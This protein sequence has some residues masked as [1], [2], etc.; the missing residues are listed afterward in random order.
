MVL[1][2]HD[3]EDES[4]TLGTQSKRGRPKGA[5]GTYHYWTRVISLSHQAVDLSHK[6]NI[7]EDVKN[8]EEL[9]E[10]EERDAVDV[11]EPIF[12]PKTFF[13]ATHNPTLDEY[14]LKEEKLYQ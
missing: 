13:I 12:N 2:D 9:E 14:S 3:N 1:I 4:V 6:Y 10:G 11:D 5:M 8:D 7:H